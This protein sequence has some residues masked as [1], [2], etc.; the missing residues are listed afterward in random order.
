MQAK[1]DDHRSTR[2]LGTDAA[3]EIAA[4]M[5]AQ[6]LL[7]D[8]VYQLTAAMQVHAEY[9]ESYLQRDRR[10][11]WVLNREVVLQFRKL[12]PEDAVWCRSSQA[13]RK[14]KPGDP[15]GRRTVSS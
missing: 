10:G 1:P 7:K 8:Y 13:W 9:G 4:W 14:R 15:P 6:Y 12:L 11:H 5:L 2:L 3:P